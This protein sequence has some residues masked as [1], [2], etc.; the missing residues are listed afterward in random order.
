MEVYQDRNIVVEVETKA[1]DYRRVLFGQQRK[2]IAL[3]A[4]VY[5]I[6]IVPTLWLTMFGAGANP[7]Q[8][9]SNDPLLVFGVFA[10]L[11]ILMAMSIY[12][13]VWKQA[14]KIEKITERTKFTFTEQ[15]LEAVAQTTA[16]KSDWSRF[17]NIKE[18]KSDFIFFP[19]ENVF[20]TI[21]QRFF[22]NDEQINDF[23]R[24]AC[25]KTGSKAKFKVNL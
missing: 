1:Q 14:D 16:T 9:K 17:Q 10:V 13:S 24:L 18:T 23:K 12:F 3:I 15:G 6:I 25:E 2:R 4:I 7:Y 8:S 11:P 21:P 20:Y 19:Q 5:L 22:Q